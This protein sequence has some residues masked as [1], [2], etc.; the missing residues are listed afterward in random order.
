LKEAEK[1]FG[2]RISYSANEYEILSGADALVIVT[3]WNE[4]RNPDFERIGELLVK[5][6]IFDGRNLFEPRRMKHL[7]F[8]YF[9]IGRNGRDF[10]SESTC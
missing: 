5:P 6:V 9:A 10:S 3:E 7:G 1:V 2:E 4:Y 8:E